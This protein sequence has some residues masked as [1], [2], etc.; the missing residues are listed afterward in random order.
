MI[1]RNYHLKSLLK[2]FYPGMRVK[3]FLLMVLSGIILM[4]VGLIYL[5][6][7]TRFL[8]IKNQIKNLFIYYQIAP[9]LSGLI[10]IIIGSLLIILGISNINRSILKTII[11]K[12][13][14]LVPEII[15]EQRK[16]GKGPRIVVIGGGTGLY[17]LLRGLKKY[18]SNITAVVTAFDSG[19][20]SGKLRDELGVLPPGDIRNCL[21][22]L[23]TEELLMKKLFQYR[24][25]NGSL[26][27]HSFGNLF[28]TAMSEVSGDFSKAIEKS[29]EIL[30]IRGRV[31]P[32]SIENVTL[33]AQLKNKQLIRGE[34]KISQSKNG[35]ES[36][37]IQPSSVLPLSET[38]QA[39]QEADAIILGPGSL[40]TSVICNLLVKN[41]PETIYQSEALKIYI[42]NVMTQ[43]GETDNYTVSMHVKEIIKYLPNNCLDY[44]LL[45]SQKLSK[46]VAAKYK[47]EGAFMVKDDLPPDFDKRIKV[48]RQEL[49]SEYNF[50][51]HHSERLAKLIIDI[52]HKEKK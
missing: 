1:K 37:F 17:T 50:A 32:S 29:S 52:I 13:V 46:Q 25:T 22:A 33:C 44:V 16:L 40:Y 19:G 47:K 42:C 9:H 6:D 45:N 51:R 30:A 18:T 41:I 10:L 31:L 26:Q 11:P 34:D 36:I 38:I 15:Y 39:I 5:I 35:I 14:D 49:L 20:S 23:S 7:L 43:P 24:F 28:I 4:A 8:W 27:G 3:R 12:Q 48:L 21:V 2:W